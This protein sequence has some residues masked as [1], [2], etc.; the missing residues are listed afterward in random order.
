MINEVYDRAV[1]GLRDLRA[2]G[3]Q[4][5]EYQ[6]FVADNIWRALLAEAQAIQERPYVDGQRATF[7]GYN[8]HVDRTL[9]DNQIR[10]RHEVSA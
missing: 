10:L 9:N 4:V 8:I 1:R 3:Y 5:D 2:A 6:V 7:F